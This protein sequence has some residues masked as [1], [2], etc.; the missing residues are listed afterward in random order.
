MQASRTALPSPLIST[1]TSWPLLT[2]STVTI[3][4][5]WACS[6]AATTEK[7]AHAR[8]PKSKLRLTAFVVDAMTVSLFN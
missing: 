7:A 3:W 1:S 4:V 2:F 8:K 5:G 6:A